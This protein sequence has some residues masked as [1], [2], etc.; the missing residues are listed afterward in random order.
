MHILNGH[1]P[2]SNL[3]HLVEIFPDHIMKLPLIILIKDGMSLI[4]YTIKR[5]ILDNIKYKMNNKDSPSIRIGN[6]FK[7]PIMS[8]TWMF[9]KV[10]G[11]PLGISND[12]DIFM[13]D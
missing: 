1:I 12:F 5:V 9:M 10:I 8:R 11:I 4:Q 3:I 7:V 2:K 13:L 6:I